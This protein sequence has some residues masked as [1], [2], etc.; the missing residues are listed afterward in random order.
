MDPRHQPQFHF[1]LQTVGTS[2]AHRT[3]EMAPVIGSGP[4]LPAPATVPV[5]VPVPDLAPADDV[6]V[7]ESSIRGNERA[8]FDCEQ[9]L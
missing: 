7:C 6:E 4:G 9:S 1:A 8:V 5:P 3:S 2:A